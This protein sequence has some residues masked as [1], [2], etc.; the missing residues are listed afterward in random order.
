MIVREGDHDMNLRSNSGLTK[1]APNLH[2]ILCAS[3]GFLCSPVSAFLRSR[4]SIESLAGLPRSRLSSPIQL[5]RIGTKCRILARS[6][7]TVELR[8]AG[9]VPCS[10]F[11]GTD[12]A[13]SSSEYFAIC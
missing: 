6:D 7:T 3:R 12:R 5:C 11:S 10:S 1:H 8:D 2:G 4:M 13:R 9:L